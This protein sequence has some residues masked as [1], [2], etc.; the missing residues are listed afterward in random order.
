MV[1]TAVVEGFL[2]SVAGLHF[3]N[4]FPSGPYF[5]LG[6]FGPT[7]FG[8][9]DAS[10]GMCG[11]MS[12]L[13][14]ERFVAHEPVPA[15]RQ[16]PANGTPLFRTLL[17]RQLRS[18]EWF[19][20]PIAFWWTGAFGPDRTVRLSREREWPRVRERIDRGEPAMMGL[21]RQQGLNPLDL[22][23]SHQVLAHGYATEGD[24]VSLRIYDPNWPDRDDVTIEL[25]AG[26]I[27]QSTGEPLFGLLSLG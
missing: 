27:R 6:P 15:D 14:R 11:G 5:R 3:A 22:R 7:L 13:V 20:T 16:P 2:P 26:A 8:L 9:N 10:G 25:E 4:R 21:V 17:D 12:W 1:Q 19:R 18:L 23:K 24:R